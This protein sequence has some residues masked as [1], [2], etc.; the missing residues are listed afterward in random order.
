MFAN[1][2]RHPS[3]I[4]PQEQF[5]A[6]HDICPDGIVDIVFPYVAPEADEEEVATAAQNIARSIG[7]GVT[8][9]M[10]Q[11]EYTLTMFLANKLSERGVDVY[12]A[13]LGKQYQDRRGNRIRPFIRFRK[14]ASGGNHNDRQSISTEDPGGSV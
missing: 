3:K 9:A 13:A 6:A 10:V 1:I 14:I 7:E 8:A 4:W 11:G 12:V 2:S 5:E